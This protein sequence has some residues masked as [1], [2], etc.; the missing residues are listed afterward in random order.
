[1]QFYENEIVINFFD[2]YSFE[3]SFQGLE[4]FHPL[5]CCLHYFCHLILM[6]YHL[7]EPTL[8]V[9]YAQIIQLERYLE[10]QLY[11]FLHPHH[12]NIHPFDLKEQYIL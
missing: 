3:I 5:Q 1:M 9:R 4:L 7:M 8:E 11:A 12:E 2:E 6:T 10:L